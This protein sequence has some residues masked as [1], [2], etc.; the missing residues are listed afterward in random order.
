MARI[1]PGIRRTGRIRQ[2]SCGEWNDTGRPGCR[3]CGREADEPLPPSEGPT[4]EDL[5]RIKERAAELRHEALLTDMFIDPNP[6]P[7]PGS[8]DPLGEKDENDEYDRLSMASFIC[9]EAEEKAVAVKVLRREAEKLVERE[10]E[11]AKD[12]DYTTADGFRVRAL[13]LRELADGLEAKD[14][15]V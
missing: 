6:Q 13:T 7:N 11:A 4:D 10:R 14:Q 3:L 5:G 9:S 15:S 8:F 1:E 12:E 2:C